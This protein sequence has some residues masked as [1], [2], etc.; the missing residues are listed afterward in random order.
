MVLP[1][2]KVSTRA[3]TDFIAKKKEYIT[4]FIVD[5]IFSI[6]PEYTWDIFDFVIV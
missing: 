2:D 3:M 4:P 1:L 5:K 6:N